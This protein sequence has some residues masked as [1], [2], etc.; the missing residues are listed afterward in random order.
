MVSVLIVWVRE[1]NTGQRIKLNATNITA[2]F[3]SSNPLKEKKKNILK[4]AYYRNTLEK[5]F[6]Y[7]NALE[8]DFKIEIYWKR[9]FTIEIYWK[10]IFTIEIYWKRIFTIEMH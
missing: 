5:D 8:N 10:R 2:V 9:I 3:T 7:R 1:T 6:Y 4:D